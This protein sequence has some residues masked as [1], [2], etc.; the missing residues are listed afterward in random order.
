MSL[1]IQQNA[2]VKPKVRPYHACPITDPMSA[3]CPVKPFQEPALRPRAL[4]WSSRHWLRKPCGDAKN[5]VTSKVCIKLAIPARRRHWVG[6]ATAS[7]DTND[8]RRIHDLYLLQAVPSPASMPPLLVVLLCSMAAIAL[9]LPL[10]AGQP[11]APGDIVVTNYNDGVASSD[12]NVTVYDGTTGVFKFTI[13][14]FNA[15]AGVIVN[16]AGCAMLD[17]A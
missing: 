3:R 11:A 10:A 15:P 6:K 9:D 16:A 14:P 1:R 12:T 5:G 8:A 13:G 4:F 17:L 2:F 7:S